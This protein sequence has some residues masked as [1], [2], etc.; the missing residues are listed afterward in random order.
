MIFANGTIKILLDPAEN[1]TESDVRETIEHESCH[2]ATGGPSETQHGPAFAE[3]MA[4]FK[5]K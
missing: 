4:R 2:V 1:L 5:L 3:C